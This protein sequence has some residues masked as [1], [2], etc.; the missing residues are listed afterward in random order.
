MVAIGLAAMTISGVVLPS[1]FLVYAIVSGGT[2]AGSLQAGSRVTTVLA[3]KITP[4]N[5]REGFVAN[6]VT[7]L[8]V[9]PDA[10]LGLP[11][12]TTHV[13]TGAIIGIGIQKGGTIDWQ[14]VKEM[15]L[16]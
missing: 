9:G 11:M 14:R 7:S 2:L 4:M 10:F 13:S 5:H 1:S 16:A 12:S 15:V 3:K 8:L 6:L